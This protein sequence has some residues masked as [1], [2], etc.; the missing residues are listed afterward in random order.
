MTAHKLTNNL[1]LKTKNLLGFTLVEL[2]IVISLLGAIATLVIATINPIEQANRTRD[3]RFKTDGS[4]LIS[5]IDRYFAATNEFTWVTSGGFSN[6]DS[7]G[8]LTAADKDVGVCG[9]ANCTVPGTLITNDELKPEFMNRDFIKKGYAGY[10][11]ATDDK[12]IFI[13]KEA[14]ASSSVYACFIPLA[15]TT[16]QKAVQDDNVY[17]KASDGTRSPTTS[18]DGANN[19]GKLTGGATWLSQGCYVCIPE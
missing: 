13:G 12:R 14:A 7:F 4:Q 5:A 1:K 15:N 8:Y 16:K 17:T 9:D 10:A 6:D 18:C 11:G 2:L 3:T 19:D